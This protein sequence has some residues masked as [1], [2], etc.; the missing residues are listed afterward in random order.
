[1]W[2]EVEKTES[3][4]WG[5]APPLFAHLLGSEF[6]L[7]DGAVGGTDVDHRDFVFC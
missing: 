1:M 2:A 6:Q 5:R 3:D 4:W 7:E